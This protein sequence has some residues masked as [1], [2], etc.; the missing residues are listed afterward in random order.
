MLTL[1]QCI[2]TAVDKTGASTVAGRM[3]DLAADLYRDGSYGS[4]ARV[5]WK[6][7]LVTA[8]RSQAAR[9]AEAHAVQYGHWDAVQAVKLGH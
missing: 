8:P 9:D 6:V 3:A 4:A 5:A 2:L 1:E 7:L